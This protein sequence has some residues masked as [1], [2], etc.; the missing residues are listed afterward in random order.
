MK[1]TRL[2]M[3]NLLA[4]SL[5]A[6]LTVSVAGQ[7][8]RTDFDLGGFGVRINPD[9]RLITVRTSLELAGMQTEL[10][11]DGEQFRKRVLEDFKDFDPDLRNKMKVFVEQYRNRHAELS[12]AE[13]PSAFVSM[14]FTLSPAPGSPGPIPIFVDFP[15]C[16]FGF[17][18]IPR[19]RG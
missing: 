12:A 5:L 10:T 19:L 2:D 3:K 13:L 8:I 17:P 18:A 4:I 11:K 6:L 9:K 7:G 1:A 16:T 15:G 14:S